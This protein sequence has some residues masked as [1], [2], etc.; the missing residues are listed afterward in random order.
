MITVIFLT[1]FAL[2]GKLNTLSADVSISAAIIGVIFEV[3]LIWV[4]VINRKEW[5][6]KKSYLKYLK[7]LFF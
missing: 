4:P 3:A 5:L 1:I 2:L 6:H 7:D